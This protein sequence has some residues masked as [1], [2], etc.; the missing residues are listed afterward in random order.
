MA[1]RDLDQL[2]R[3]RQEQSRAQYDYFR[4]Y[5]PGQIS[6][7]A[8]DSF[9]I[10]VEMDEATAPVGGSIVTGSF[11]S[12]TATTGSVAGDVSADSGATVWGAGSLFGDLV[13]RSGSRVRVAGAGLIGA[14]SGAGAVTTEDF[15]SYQPGVAFES[16][17]STGLAGSW[18]FYDLGLLDDR[19]PLRSHRSRRHA[20]QP[21]DAA[22][23]GES[24]MLFQTNT[25]A[26]F[27]TEVS[28]S[29]R[30]PARSR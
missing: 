4:F 24:Q 17:A 22:L 9:Q 12:S 20:N 1:D 2:R 16:G 15:E 8:G 7:A 23:T 21:T 3:P 5:E 18:S 28:G 11:G 25:S 13:A 19:R 6:L 29:H 10:G 26:D 14:N 30:L 27:A